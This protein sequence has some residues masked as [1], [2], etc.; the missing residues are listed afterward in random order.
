M[1]KNRI[2]GRNVYRHSLKMPRAATVTAATL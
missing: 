2:R 1:R